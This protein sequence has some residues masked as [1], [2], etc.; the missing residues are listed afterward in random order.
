MH[1]K[2]NITFT[3]LIETRQNV[4]GTFV[5]TPYK[6]DCYTFMRSRER[7]FFFFVALR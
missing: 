6:F 2:I 7:E 3:K 5:L 1:R 4:S